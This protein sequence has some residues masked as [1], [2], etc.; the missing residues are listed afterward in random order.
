MPVVRAKLLGAWLV[1]VAIIGMTMAEPSVNFNEA[2]VA[3]YRLPE[4][5][6]TAQG[7]PITTASQWTRRRAELLRL[8]EDEIYGRSPDRPDRLRFVITSIEPAAL[9]GLATRREVT[10]YLA[11][12]GTGPKLHLLLYV[13]N[14]VTGPAPVF[15]GLNFKG[16]HAVAHDPGITLRSRWLAGEEGSSPCAD[17]SPRGAEASRWQVETILTRGYALATM[18]YEDIEPDIDDGYQNGV[19]PLYYQPDQTRPA[20]N[21]WGAVAAWAWG[22]CRALDYLET[23]ASV[24]ARRVALVGHS[25]LG[26][27]A[28]WAGALDERFALVISNNSGCCGAAL[29]RRDFGE[30]V[31][32]INSRYPHW[33]C[34]NFKKYSDQ[35]DQLPVDQH[36]LIAL[37]APRPVYIASGAED[38]WADPRGEFLGAKHAT[39]VYRL[40]GLEG[41]PAEEMPPVDHPIAGTIGYHIRHGGHD[42]LPYDWQQ[43]LSF[44]DRHLSRE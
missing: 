40:L 7:E 39:P 23:D 35:V 21:E 31:R 27:A 2:R 11:K 5:L 29:S 17:E 19:Q 3:P 33:F 26:K 20:P 12:N 14:H 38:L 4:L 18:C 22:L 15:L 9:H 32:R 6:K 42:V 34:E 37:L 8:F 41:L 24:D 16:N 1:M 44:A 25:R 43:F 28:L 30:T 13:P 10:L 36:M